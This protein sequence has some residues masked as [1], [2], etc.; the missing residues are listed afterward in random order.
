VGVDGA[1][2]LVHKVDLLNTDIHKLDVV[3]RVARLMAPLP[4]I[5]KQAHRHLRLCIPFGSEQTHLVR[6]AL[7][8]ALHEAY[9]P[10]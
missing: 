6:A 10:V 5:F 4:Q 2:H 3:V 8:E 7:F 9:T 1:D